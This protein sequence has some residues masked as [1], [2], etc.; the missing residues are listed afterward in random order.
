MSKQILVQP[1]I[2]EKMD[3]LNETENKY[4]FIVH[5]KA[6]KIEIKK[7]IEIFEVMTNEKSR[8]NFIILI[9]PSF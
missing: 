6:N 8:I 9:D 5:K 7:A 2:S 1:I 3:R 4:G